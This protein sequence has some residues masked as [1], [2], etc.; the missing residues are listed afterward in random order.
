MRASVRIIAA[1]AACVFSAM[2]ACNRGEIAKPLIVILVPSQDNPFF[3]SE[4]DA[5]AARAV[6][7][8][9]SGTS[10]CGSTMMPIARTT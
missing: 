4:A 7:L 9:L 6:S 10:G 5:A 1:A 2:T 8:G 3:K